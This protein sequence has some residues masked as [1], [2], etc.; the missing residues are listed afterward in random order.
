MMMMPPAVAAH[1]TLGERAVLY[2]VAQEVKLHGQCNLYTDQIAAF[3]GV[4]R[5]T[6]RN[7]LRE[8]KQLCLIRIDE[9]RLSARYNDANRITITNREW[10]TWLAH[11]KETVK[12]SKPTY[13]QESRGKAF[14]RRG[15]YVGEARPMKRAFEGV[16]KVAA[17]PK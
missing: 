17:G 8:A 4:G 16:A 15:R 12:S 7:A 5:S 13:Q 2:V 3:A 1:F 11:R 14:A 10:C 9:R 6:C